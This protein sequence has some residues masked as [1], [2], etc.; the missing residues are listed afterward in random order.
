MTVESLRAVT[1]VAP[2]LSEWF[3]R[4]EA[5]GLR[6]GVR[7]RLLAHGLLIRLARRGELPEAAV[8]SFRLLGPLLCASAEQQ[9][10]Y[11]RMLDELA[12]AGGDGRL[13]ASTPPPP[14]SGSSSR[15]A[16]VV[17]AGLMVIVLLLVA[18]LV[19]PVLVS[20]SGAEKAAPRPPAASVPAE[21][22][23]GVIHIDPGGSSGST[24]AVAASDI[25]QPVY[26]PQRSL[27]WAAPT[28]PTWAA[29][30]RAGLAALGGLALMVIGWRLWRHLRL[31]KPY[32]EAQ[33][34]RDDEV[35]QRLLRDCAE[36][37]RMPIGPAVSVLAPVS[38]ALRQRTEGDRHTLHVQATVAASIR[39]GGRV[40]Q[41][42]WRTVRQTPEY[43]ALV[44]R[45][46]AGDHQARYH[47]AVVEALRSRG[48]TIELFFYRQSPEHGCWRLA[49]AGD[50]EDGA[51]GGF[52]H[53]HD[54]VSVTTLLARFPLHRLLVF[55]DAGGALD[56]DTGESQ[57]WTVPARLFTQRA[58]FTPRPVA[59][60]G[61]AERWVS[62][63][64]GLDV[65]L[66]PMEDA[67]LGTLADWLASGRAR[68][69]QH[70]QAPYRYPPLLQADELDWAARRVAPPPELLARLMVE[71]RS[72]LGPQ[73]M[74]WLAACAV[75]PTLAWPLT[76]MLGRRVFD[77]EGDDDVRA[78][79][80]ATLGAL[81]WFRHGRLPDWLRGPLLEELSADE[82]ARLRDELLQRMEDAVTPPNGA[83]AA[84][85]DRPVL[86]RV[87]R[88][89]LRAWLRGRRDALARDLLMV[90]FLEPSLAPKLAQR[91]P[92]VFRRW[93]FRDGSP[94]RGLRPVVEALLVLPLLAGVAALPG[95]W[96]RVGPGEEMTAVAAQQWSVG[97]GAVK[98]LG[99]SADGWQVCTRSAD[100]T[101]RRWRASTGTAVTGDGW[102]AETVEPTRATR[103]DGRQIARGYPGGVLRLT[104]AAMNA[105]LTGHTA[106]ITAL[107]YSPDGSQLASAGA[108]GRVVVWDATTAQQI[109]TLATGTTAWRSVVSLRAGARSAASGTCS[110]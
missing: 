13:V 85:A 105:M 44:E 26:V 92:A 81:P 59:N 37:G 97:A 39:H 38:R 73:R 5:A 33:E 75:F 2:S 16:W 55:G 1:P 24:F 54:R 27:R 78:L 108:D 43:L 104:G 19:W 40:L 82:T 12:L 60:W 45:A 89:K 58:W 28:S 96:D 18:W 77:R 69:V 84:G 62:E 106:T 30:L 70:P 35:E 10:N 48:V 90:R 11:A 68:L 17:F 34:Q 25:P 107:T 41:P 63:A 9:R 99:V 95:V 87:S 67:A 53:A 102:C 29:P 20:G 14:D 61:R 8:D 57:P 65:L 101:V 94:L 76:L 22:A 50:E 36:P 79:G 52:R 93:L 32:L 91:L 103:P 88:L 6:A 51:G 7:E 47:E 74:R 64:A 100:D 49:A 80:V 110:A 109:K 31:R 46:G 42:V 23:S 56:P 72:Y 98:A 71:L 15:G 86:A 21:P 4:I 3:D 83:A 66:L